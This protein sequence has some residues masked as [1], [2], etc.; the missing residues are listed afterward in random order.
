LRFR[1]SLIL[2][3]L[4]AFLVFSSLGAGLGKRTQ[5][6]L[7]AH[8]EKIL[9]AIKENTAVLIVQTKLLTVYSVSC[10]LKFII[11]RFFTSIA[12]IHS[13]RFTPIIC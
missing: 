2:I 4:G 8:Q 11:I 6:P 10:I 3:L 7:G 12:S 9:I 13:R 5:K 1:V